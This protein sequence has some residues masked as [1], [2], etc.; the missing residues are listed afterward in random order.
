MNSSKIKVA[1]V[2]SVI[3]LSVSLLNTAYAQP[4][5]TLNPFGKEKKPEQYE[6]KKLV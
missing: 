4:T 6:E 3:L 1:R 2:V 5:W